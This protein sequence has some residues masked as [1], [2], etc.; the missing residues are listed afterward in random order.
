MLHC[1]AGCDVFGIDGSVYD[2][3]Q[4]ILYWADVSSELAIVVPSLNT[5][6]QRTV[7]FGAV[8]IFFF[9]LLC[10]DDSISLTIGHLENKYTIADFWQDLQIFSQIFSKMTGSR[11]Q[12]TSK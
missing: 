11:R 3:T 4:R 6:R 5:S 10:M 2:G 1:V 12:Q 9:R 8:F 7:S